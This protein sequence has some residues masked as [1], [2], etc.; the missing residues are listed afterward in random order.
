MLRKVIIRPL[1]SNYVVKELR[2]KSTW[3]G[4]PSF[5]VALSLI[6]LTVPLFAGSPSEEIPA[7]DQ[8]TGDGFL[9]VA[10]RAL[11]HGDF[12]EVERLIKDLTPNDVVGSAVKA[13]ILIRRGDYEDAE[14][15]LTSA[16]EVDPFGEAALE[17]GLLMKLVGRESEAVASLKPILAAA[18]NQ[19]TDI[20]LL[21]LGR[22][23]QA[24]G[25]YRAAN[26]YFRRAASLAPGD[27]AINTAW[28]ELLLEKHNNKDAGRSFQIALSSDSDWAPAH[29]GVA[30][31]LRDENPSA[32]IEAAK[33]SLKI[34]KALIGAHLLIAEL[35][36]D[37]G[38]SKVAEASLVRAF[39]INPLDLRMR[40]LRAAI[41]YIEGRP[42][43]FQSEVSRVL[44]INPQ[45]GNVY[46]IVGA[47]VARHYRFDEAVTLVNRA[48]ALDPDN[49]QAQSELGM[50]L[51]RTGDE[52]A[53]RVV[54]K[55]SFE[56]D[57]FNVIT[58]NL[59]KM[60][61]AV[62]EFVT[63]HR[64]NL[65]VRL[66][67]DEA[68]VLGEYA[69][70]LAGDALK[71]LSNR[72]G[73][74]LKD[75]ILIEIFPRH[76]DFAVRNVGLPGMVGALGACFGRVVT[77][78]SPQAWPPG[79]FNWQATLWHEMA[80][81]ITLH[82]SN[83]RVPRWLT[84]GISVYEERLANSAWGRGREMAFA[85]ALNDGAIIKLRDLNAGFA[86]PQTIA[87]AYY[88]ASLVVEHLVEV[89]GES[90]LH[91]LLRAYGD[92]LDTD[93]ALVRAAN[94]NLDQLQETFTKALTVRFDA[95]SKA[96]RTFEIKELLE[97][98]DHIQT[99]RSLAL[100]HPE[101]YELQ[102][103]LG[104]ALYG[105]GQLDE[106]IDVLKGAAQL[107]PIASGPNSPH[108]LLAD[109][110]IKQGRRDEAMSEFA[111]LL[112]HE[113][114]GLEPARRL[115]ALAE[116]T[117]TAEYKVL[118]YSRIAAIDPFDSGPH[119]VLGR[120]AVERGD[121]DDAIREFRV[122]LAAGPIDTVVAYTDLAEAYLL[123][124]Q[125]ENAKREALLALE[126]APSYERA[127]ELLL[128][129]IQ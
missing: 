57:P 106:A 102:L 10:T 79:T 56:T 82:M 49:S 13:R 7:F 108:A 12:I 94:I 96:L 100:N 54:L 87:L 17:L 41:A 8:A 123:N 46:R 34:D 31:S 110:A 95:L 127:Q 93:T 77:L 14:Q 114:T 29:L 27:P 62:E 44:S 45:Y 18:R 88:E 76:D 60:L 61:D 122:G 19:R 118:A 98:G 111:T 11:G 121:Y 128:R 66:H 85:Q 75:P 21:R 23:A 40:S 53:A 42:D 2:F 26:Q 59:L 65:I 28:G 3:C 78:D 9:R 124:R 37:D 73:V 91:E 112:D 30:Q 55:R 38:R 47:Q 67:P 4:R 32:A 72:Y 117:D 80:H 64:D 39:E 69:V 109:I 1:V 68:N 24:L 5:F 113:Y 92:G 81:V 58:F 71:T 22:A 48:L 119:G 99:L 70:S 36:Y 20:E 63:I 101:N 25:Q 129:A 83:N 116:E 16:V 90:V 105:A 89:Y 84:E 52:D 107:V 126:L 51:L 74:V 15:I 6:C 43:D 120:L 86:Q 103:D 50:H 35:A 115:A 125:T 104:Q 33:Q 97:D